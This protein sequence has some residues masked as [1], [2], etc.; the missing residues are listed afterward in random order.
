MSRAVVLCDL[1]ECVVDLL[2]E[3]CR[4]YHQVG[5][6]LLTPE[7]FTKYRWEEQVN[8]P[9]LFRQVLKSGGLFSSAPPRPG[10]VEALG[11]LWN[12]DIDTYLVT[13]VMA[14]NA[15]AY[16][17]KM[18]WLWRHMPWFPR[19]RVIFTQH[20]HLVRGDYLIDD[21]SD[22]LN[23]WADAQ[24]YIR[25]IAGGMALLIDRPHNV[26]DVRHT[27]VDDLAHAVECVIQGRLV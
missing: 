19:D 1:D 14:D 6:E 15:R 11:R 23:K 10:A 7:H 2:A 3:W 18:G 16:D 13:A 21:S 26:S 24:P 20:K 25:G 4:H 5:G 17:A 12:R 27:R 9:D 22:N 8:R